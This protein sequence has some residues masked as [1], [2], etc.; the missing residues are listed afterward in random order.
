M[1]RKS[2]CSR[3]ASLQ[4]RE[5]EGHGRGRRLGRRWL[6]QQGEGRDGVAWR[7][8]RQAGS[9]EAQEGNEAAEA[10]AS[11]HGDGETMQ[12][13]VGDA[14]SGRRRGDTEHGGTAAGLGA[15]R[16]GWRGAHLLG[17]STAEGAP[18]AWQA[19]GVARSRAA[20]RSRES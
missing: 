11:G 17:C 18:V 1:R 2:S 3:A 13:R 20:A 19:G 12:R 16:E 7:S 15:G 4:A 8:R 10:W 14:G 5:E 6:P 9:R